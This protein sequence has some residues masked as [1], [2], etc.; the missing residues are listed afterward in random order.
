MP[1]RYVMHHAYRR[2][3]IPWEML[4]TKNAAVSGAVGQ[5]SESG[6]RHGLTD[7]VSV[8][9]AIRSHLPSA[10]RCHCG[11]HR[12]DEPPPKKVTGSYRHERTAIHHSLS[13]ASRI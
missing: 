2:A 13:G 7:V 4:S 6:G 9:T 3:A 5:K 11:W 12:M 10:V 8:Q 1:P